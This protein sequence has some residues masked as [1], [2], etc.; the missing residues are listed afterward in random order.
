MRV[1]QLPDGYRSWRRF[2]EDKRAQ[3]RQIDAA[4]TAFAFGCALI[5]GYPKGIDQLR[6]ALDRL[7]R[8]TSIEKW[9]R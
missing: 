2:K 7:H 9:G 8:E 5:P 4:V 1:K 6:R 3:L